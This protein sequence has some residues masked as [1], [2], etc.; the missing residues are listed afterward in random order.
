MENK[1]SEA[2]LAYDALVAESDIRPE[3]GE[4]REDVDDVEHKT[5]R[6]AALSPNP[7]D[8]QILDNRLFPD[9]GYP[10]LNMLE[11]AE[12]FPEIINHLISINVKELLRRNRDMGVAEAIAKVHTP[13]TIGMSREGRVDIIVTAKGIEVT[14]QRESENKLLG[15]TP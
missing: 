12:N 9:T 8:M 5:A 11:V 10:Y 6:E 1:K 3:R 2:D 15:G 13:V 14:K 4:G 7:S